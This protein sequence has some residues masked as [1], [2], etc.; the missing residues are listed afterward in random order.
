VLSLLQ[1]EPVASA[2]AAVLDREGRERLRV[3]RFGVST[4]EKRRSDA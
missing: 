2:L 1:T 3:E 4:T